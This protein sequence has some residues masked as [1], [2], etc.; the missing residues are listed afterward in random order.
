MSALVRLTVLFA[1]FA[2]QAA[3]AASCDLALKKIP[4]AKGEATVAVLKELYACDKGTAEGNFDTLMKQSG[5]T[6]VLT[7]LALTAIDAKSFKP[8]WDMMD[9][10]PDYS[11]RK[12]VSK[13]VGEACV[14]H[15][16]VQPFLQGAY[17]ALRDVQFGHWKPALE[18]CTAEP[19]QKWVETTIT[20]PPTT[21]FDDKYS[22][23]LAV[24]VGQKKAA[25]L[26]ILQ[27]A[28]A[29]AAKGGGPLGEILDKMG[30]AVEPEMG[31][32]MSPENKKALTDAMLAVTADAPP[33]KVKEIADRLFTAGSTEAAVSLLPKVYPDRTV[34][35]KLSYGFASL[36]ICD[37][38]MVLH[39]AIATDPAKRWSIQA[40]VEPL[41]RAF[42]PKLKCTT[43]EPW[44]V[45]TT[46]EPLVDAAAI[47]PW[48]AEIIAG[49]TKKG[50]T[51]KG[52]KEKDAALN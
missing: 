42:K 11:A 1:L 33:D 44:Q 50:L 41:G 8:V 5:D 27:I 39:Y 24:Y 4:T 26:P 9:K 7:T 10:V 38:E 48:A 19:V 45:L 25:A 31:E 21:S 6:D 52:F 20:K 46:P 18:A 28:A 17:F 32:T 40:D 13:G 34:G 36:E 22:T 37:K 49:Y 35:G 43:P 12:R 2:P 16:D 51:V 15:A 3:S 14:A 29:A 47:E 23:L 30:S